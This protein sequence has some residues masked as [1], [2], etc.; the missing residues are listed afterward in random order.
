MVICHI[1]LGKILKKFELY[2]RCWGPTCI[3]VLNFIKISQKVAEIQFSKWQLYAILDF[4]NSIFWDQFC[5][6]IPNF[7]KIGQTIERYRDFCD[8]EDGGGRHLGFSKIR[9][10][11]GRSAVMGQC[12]SPCQISSKLVKRLQRY[13]DL[14][15][16]KMAAVRHLEFLTFEFFNGRSG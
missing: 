13:G 10:F 16:F 9:N 12:A 11:N 1:R 3:T 5:I 8:F 15:V 14:T 4:W 6:S 7:V 2:V